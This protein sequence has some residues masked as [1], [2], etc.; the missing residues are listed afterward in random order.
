MAAVDT[1]ALMTQVVTSITNQ[2][3]IESIAGDEGSTRFHEPTR[4]LLNLQEF[5][6]RQHRRTT[7]P[8]PKFN[9]LQ[10]FTHYAGLTG[11]RPGGR[12]NQR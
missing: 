12:F 4:Q 1:S 10:T 7:C 6:S 9:G 11:S 2:N 3:G 8:V 5:E